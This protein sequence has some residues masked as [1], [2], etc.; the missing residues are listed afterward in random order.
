[1][2]E[3]EKE[4]W[5]FNETVHSSLEHLVKNTS[6]KK[7]DSAACVR[8]RSEISAFLVGPLESRAIVS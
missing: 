6:L 4:R 7:K 3:N 5:Y 2:R 8:S 1:M